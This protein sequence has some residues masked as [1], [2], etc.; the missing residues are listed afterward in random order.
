MTDAIL[1]QLT[2]YGV[3]GLVV[4]AQGFVI[5]KLWATYQ[6]LIERYNQ[7]TDSYNA[8]LEE[9]TKAQTSMLAE[10]ASRARPRS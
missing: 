6:N 10:L 1:K 8:K 4:I 2:G 5:I 3:L 7:K 9:N